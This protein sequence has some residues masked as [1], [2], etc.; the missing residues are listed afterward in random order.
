M[1]Q[2]YEPLIWYQYIDD[3]S[4]IRTDGGTKFKQFLKE[5]KDSHPNLNFSHEFSREKLLFLN[6][7]VNVSYAVL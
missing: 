2:Q 5:P 1:K 7:L 3:I 6:D 4:F